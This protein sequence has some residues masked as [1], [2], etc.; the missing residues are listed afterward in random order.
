M[1]PKL[2]TNARFGAWLGT[3]HGARAGCPVGQSGTLRVAKVRSPAA[4][5]FD[6]A[7]SPSGRIERRA[8]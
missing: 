1:A 3:S 8:D 4:E 6:T 5:S 7:L 2:L